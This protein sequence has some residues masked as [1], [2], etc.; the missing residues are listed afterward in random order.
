MLQLLLLFRG[1]IEEFEYWINSPVQ[2]MRVVTKLRFRAITYY[3][4][5]TITM[6]ECDTF[7]YP[8]LTYP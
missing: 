7:H 3:S 5:K 8:S 1:C 2:A 6:K 4:T